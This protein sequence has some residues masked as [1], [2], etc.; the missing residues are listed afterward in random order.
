MHSGKSILLA[1]LVLPAT[2]GSSG[3]QTYDLRGH[4]PSQG[5]IV[6][7]RS[8]TK[9]PGGV[10]S[11]ESGDTVNRVKSVREGVT[12]SEKEIV[13]TAGPKLTM[14]RLKVAE[15]WWKTS[16]EKDGSAPE[17]TTVDDPL[18]G[19]TL[20]IERRDD[21]WQTTMFGHE[22]NERQKARLRKPFFDS[23][24]VYPAKPVAIG[25]SWVVEGAKLAMLQGYG[26]ALAAD[27]KATYTLDKVIQEAG[28]RRALISYRLELK[29]RF[30]DDNQ[31][32]TD[33]NLGGSG[34]IRRSLKTYLDISDQFTGQLQAAAT[35]TENGRKSNLTETG[36]IEVSDSQQIITPAS[37]AEV[38]H[39]A[40]PAPK[41]ALAAAPQPQ[42]AEEHKSFFR[43]LFSSSKTDGEESARQPQDSTQSSCTG[44]PLPCSQRSG[45]NCGS[46]SGCFNG[47]YCNGVPSESCFGKVQF[48]CSATPGCYWQS[49]TKTCSGVLLCAGKGSFACGATPGCSWQDACIGTATACSSLSP[50]QCAN[51]PGCSSR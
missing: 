23:A 40:T 33:L 5:S 26:D 12:I 4:A 43:R 49:F 38:V 41:P 22:P 39:R 20:L 31:V 14:L 10:L 24:E 13:Q 2:A 27:G 3:A 37:R 18:V 32:P 47:G 9:M 46:G 30:L 34:K 15:D 48:T 1:L 28:E 25:E 6:Q 50:S 19:E 36:P 44:V 42:P 8:E 17:A 51:Q 11:V 29:V 45:F 16:F 7:R 35:V 21:G